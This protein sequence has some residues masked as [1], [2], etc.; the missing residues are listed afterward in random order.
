M[1]QSWAVTTSIASFFRFFRSETPD[2][3]S[4]ESGVPR[5]ERALKM[6]RM[7]DLEAEMREA[8]SPLPQTPPRRRSNPWP[9]P[10]T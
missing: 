9:T 1:L 7:S 4:G 5:K 3:R 6:Q 2:D 10:K 8:R